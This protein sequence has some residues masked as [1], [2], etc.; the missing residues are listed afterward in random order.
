MSV[1]CHQATGQHRV[2]NRT[3]GSCACGV[4]GS[5]FFWASLCGPRWERGALGLGKGRGERKKEAP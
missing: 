2:L 5:C 1:H 4:W 3:L